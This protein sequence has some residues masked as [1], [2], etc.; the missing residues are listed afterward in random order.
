VD[1]RAQRV[2]RDEDGGVLGLAGGFGI[3]LVQA[4]AIIPG[5]LPALLL[6]LPLVLPVVLL[7][8]AVGLFVAVA[9]GI[10]RLVTGA[11]AALS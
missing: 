11:V 7:G 3:L 6:A 10:R 2:P 9:R 4:G 8:V 5:L 1:T